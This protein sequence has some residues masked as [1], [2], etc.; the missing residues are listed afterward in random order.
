MNN[1][2]PVQQPVCGKGKIA[3]VSYGV[4]FLSILLDCYSHII[5]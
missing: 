5:I 1:P 4:E 3:L 2:N